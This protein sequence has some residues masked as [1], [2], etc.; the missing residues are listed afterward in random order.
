MADW[1]QNM[2]QKQKKASTLALN[3]LAQHLSQGFLG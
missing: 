3:N 2:K 1:D